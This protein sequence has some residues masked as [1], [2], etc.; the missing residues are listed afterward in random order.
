ML[1]MINKGDDDA[2]EDDQAP[3]VQGKDDDGDGDDDDGDDEGDDDNDVDVDVDE[4]GR[5]PS[6]VA[7]D[8]SSKTKKEVK[9]RRR[10]RKSWEIKRRP[11]D[12]VSTYSSQYSVVYIYSTVVCSSKSN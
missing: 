6:A 7:V 9:K 11:A 8:R 10:R 4:D 3:A 2:V 5:K 1:V 12:M